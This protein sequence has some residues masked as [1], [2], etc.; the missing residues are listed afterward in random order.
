MKF[1]AKTRYAA[2]VL[3]DLARH[4][5]TTPIPATLLSQHT[6][7]S[8]QF[9][10]QILKPLKQA[11]M[12]KSTRGASGGHTLAKHPSQITMC[13]V[14]RLMEGGIHVT[15]CCSPKKKRMFC[16]SEGFCPARTVW[17]RVSD[18]IEKELA[19]ITLQHLLDEQLE[20]Q[21]REGAM[22]FPVCRFVAAGRKLPSAQ[23]RA[24]PPVRQTRHRL[25]AQ[26]EEAISA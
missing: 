9:I 14:V 12:T 26:D 4:P 8:V 6:G 18:A 2:R 21:K 19:G 22:I 23:S 16:T 24:T 25:L 17:Q 10:E 13:D 5:T 3:L 11:G 1:S 20:L 15:Q 7:V